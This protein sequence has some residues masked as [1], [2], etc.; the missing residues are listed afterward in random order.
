ML[1]EKNII[2]IYLRCAIISLGH[3]HHVSLPL[4]PQ[5]FPIS[6]SPCFSQFIINYILFIGSS[7]LFFIS[8]RHLSYGLGD[9]SEG[10]S[11]QCAYNCC[12]LTVGTFSMPSFLL[13]FFK[14][15]QE[16]IPNVQT[17]QID[18]HNFVSRRLSNKKN[19]ISRLNTCMNMHIVWN[20]APSPTAE[21]ECN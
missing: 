3:R 2:I 1:S 21:K 9:R 8:V 5:A 15:M 4:S 20:A 12:G 7:Y 11:I 16:I 10:N 18:I 19:C 13:L 17:L 6:L 14:P